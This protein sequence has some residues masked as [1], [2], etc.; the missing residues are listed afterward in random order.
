MFMGLEHMAP[1]GLWYIAMSAGSL[2][3]LVGWATKIYW[4]RW[5]GAIMMLGLWS[6]VATGAYAGS[7]FYHY[8]PINT[9]FG[10][11]SIFAAINAW[12]VVVVYPKYVWEEWQKAVIKRELRKMKV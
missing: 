9:G 12:N 1:Q 8:V 4:L 5:L 6:F 3:Q 11:Y 2:F 10:N 7:P